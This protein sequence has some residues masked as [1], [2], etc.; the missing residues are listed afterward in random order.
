MGQVFRARQL[1]LG[2]E[3]AIKTPLWVGR[4]DA[5]ESAR[6][7]REAEAIA[8]LRH[9]SIVSLFQ[10]GEH[11]GIPFL[12]ME[13][14]AG[15]SLAQTMNEVRGQGIPDDG[16][17]L[18][19]PELSWTEAVAE[20]ALQLLD[21][22]GAAH[23]HGLVHRDVKP[24]NAL[25]EPGGRVRLFDFGLARFEHS[26]TLTGTGEVVGTP[27]YMAPEVL[28]DPRAASPRSDLYA[29]GVLM[30]ELLA[31]ERPF[32]GGSQH[33]RVARILQGNPPPLAHLTRVPRALSAILEKAMHR[34]PGRRYARAEDFAADLVAAREGREVSARPSTALTR[35]GRRIARHPVATALIALLLAATTVA[36]FQL[37]RA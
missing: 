7:R 31:L 4:L 22:L 18:G 6:F 36:A 1:S 8:Q 2:R 24:A 17:A 12:V 19:R 23:R 32:G 20:V 35:A 13:F 10:V 29:M 27:D 26:E 15:R 21:A 33:L 5:V 16:S 3:V 28:E 11:E 14:V 30:Y 34:I 25:V 37:A 9:P